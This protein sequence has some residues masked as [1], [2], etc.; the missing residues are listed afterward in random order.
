MFG[1]VEVD[2]RVKE[3]LKE[4]FSKMCPIFKNTEISRDDIGEFMK[5]YAEEHNIM[6]QPC[7][8]L[9]RIMKREKVLLATLLLKWYLE[10][11]LKV[12]KVHHVIKFTPEP[13]FTPFRDAVADARRAG[14]ADPS[15]AIIADT[16]EFVSC[17][18]TG[19]PWD[20]EYFSMQKT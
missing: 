19:K 3:H 14:D 6:A 7:C 20:G 11:G 9:I 5:A 10:H 2:I 16:M 8:S 15:K 18:N 4:K 1:Y 17:L 13:C 12:T